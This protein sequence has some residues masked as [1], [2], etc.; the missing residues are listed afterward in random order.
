MHSYS[1]MPV[2]MPHKTSRTK[3][4]PASMSKISPS[5]PSTQATSTHYFHNATNVVRPQSRQT[6]YKRGDAKRYAYWSDFCKHIH[7]TQATHNIEPPTPPPHFESKENEPQPLFRR[8]Q[9]DTTDIGA[10]PTSSRPSTARP[11]SSQIPLDTDRRSVRPPTPQ[12]AARHDDGSISSRIHHSRSRM[13]HL[14]LPN[15]SAEAKKLW[16]GMKEQINAQWKK[17]QN[18]IHKTPPQQQTAIAA[19]AARDS[20]VGISC[21]RTQLSRSRAS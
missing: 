1:A 14:S 19:A 7:N 16:S 4:T 6:Q 2:T 12:R 10:T 11:A 9:H 15:D 20:S 13:S 21:A 3:P 17:Y 8:R 5:R 18:K